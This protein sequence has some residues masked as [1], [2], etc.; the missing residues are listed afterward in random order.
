MSKSEKK[1]KGR[2]AKQ[3]RRK[4]L[5]RQKLINRILWFGLPSMAV[6]GLIVFGVIRQAN[7][8]PLDVLANLRLTNI[9]GNPSAPITIVEFGDFG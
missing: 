6:M 3:E 1:R 4:Q 7:Q 9:D 5:K 8:P 2:Q